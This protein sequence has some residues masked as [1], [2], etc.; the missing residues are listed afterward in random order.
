[1]EKNFGSIKDNLALY[2]D[3][4]CAK[5]NKNVLNQIDKSIEKIFNKIKNAFSDESADKNIICD[6]NP[7]LKNIR[8]VIRQLEREIDELSNKKERIEGEL[9]ELKNIFSNSK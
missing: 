2:H 9:Q 6:L 5:T 1:M 8:S 4:A 7:E 3:D